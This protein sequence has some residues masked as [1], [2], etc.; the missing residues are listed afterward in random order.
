MGW[1]VSIWDEVLVCRMVCLYTG[2][3]VS[4]RDGVLV[5]GRGDS[6]WDGVLVYESTKNILM[7][8][9][10]VSSKFC[11]RHGQWICRESVSASYPSQLQSNT[12]VPHPRNLAAYSLRSCALLPEARKFLGRNDRVSNEDSLSETALVYYCQ[13]S[14]SYDVISGVLG[15]RLESNNYYEDIYNTYTS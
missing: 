11:H 6:I 4:I 5:Y 9:T 15:G 12:N 1:G 10:F 13:S 3:V 7:G 14:R 8:Q 2:C